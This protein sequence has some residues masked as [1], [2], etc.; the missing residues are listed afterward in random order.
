MEV[1]LC[2]ISHM[3]VGDSDCNFDIHAVG[4]VI[5]DIVYENITTN[6]RRVE[7]LHI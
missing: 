3:A 6:I 5:E 4:K 2:L 7:R 1:G